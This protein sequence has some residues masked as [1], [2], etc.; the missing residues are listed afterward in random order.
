MQQQVRDK[1]VWHRGAN[2]EGE[3]GEWRVEGGGLPWGA[4]IELHAMP[5]I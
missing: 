3:G 1:D 2:G 5:Q 4:A